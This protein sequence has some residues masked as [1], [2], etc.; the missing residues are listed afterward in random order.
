VPEKDG[1]D[2]ILDQWQRERPDLDASPMGVIGRVSRLSR[3]LERRLDPVYARHGLEAGLFD[4]LATLRRV[5]APHR[6]RPSDLAQAV[7]LTSSGT[8]KR[9]DR[10]ETAG[11]IRRRPD[12]QDRRGLLIELTPDGLRLVDS[13]VTDHVANEHHLIQA[14][15]PAE[16]KHLAR[17]LRKLLL[18]LP[19]TEPGLEPAARPTTRQ[20]SHA[21]V[22]RRGEDGPAG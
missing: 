19:P 2:D 11:L 16:R 4:I 10:L 17:L 9:L 5:G 18:G 6:M 22:K 13:A 8:T 21:N 7:M 1:V 3:E 14:L 15:T 20:P 12:P